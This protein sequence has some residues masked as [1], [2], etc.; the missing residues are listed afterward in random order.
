MESICI[1]YVVIIYIIK[2][3]ERIRAGYLVSDV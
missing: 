1:I 3:D 2:Y